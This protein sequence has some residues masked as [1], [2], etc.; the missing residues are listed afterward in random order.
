MRKPR[1]GPRESRSR[2]CSTAAWAGKS[3]SLADLRARAA[4][5]HRTGREEPL[6]GDPAPV[7]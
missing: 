5:R 6:D 1:A 2:M 3:R 7:R 4:K